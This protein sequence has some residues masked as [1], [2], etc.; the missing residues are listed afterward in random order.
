M[1]AD[2]IVLVGVAVKGKT[3]PQKN[4][5]KEVTEALQANKNVPSIALEPVTSQDTGQD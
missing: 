1:V 5:I 4:N 2:F 3:M